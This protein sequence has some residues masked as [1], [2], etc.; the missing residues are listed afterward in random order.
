MTKTHNY[1]I[2]WGVLKE[3]PGRLAFVAVLGRPSSGGW[4]A[5]ELVKAGSRAKGGTDSVGYATLKRPDGTEVQLPTSNQ[6]FEDIDGQYK[7]SPGDVTLAEFDAFRASRPDSY[8]IE[9][10]LSFVQKHRH[11]A[12]MQPGAK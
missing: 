11:A 12:A 7:E 4:P 9:S 10:L 6:L 5:N 8:T 2:Q 3:D 1:M